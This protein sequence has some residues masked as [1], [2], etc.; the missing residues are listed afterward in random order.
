M[1]FKAKVWGSARG[2][3]SMGLSGCSG[4]DGLWPRNRGESAIDHVL[5]TRLYVSHLIACIEAGAIF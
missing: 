4:A 1:L 2:V 5:A 3:D